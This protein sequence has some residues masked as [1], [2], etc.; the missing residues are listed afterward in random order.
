MNYVLAELLRHMG[1]EGWP[2]LVA[3]RVEQDLTLF[4]LADDG[5]LKVDV[6]PISNLGDLFRESKQI[7]ARG[8]VL[9]LELGEEDHG[10]QLCC[11]VVF[12]T[13]NRDADKNFKELVKA[14]L[15]WLLDDP[16]SVRELQS[17]A[18]CMF[19]MGDLLDP[20]DATVEETLSLVSRRYEE[21][22]G[23]PRMVLGSGTVFADWCRAKN[24][25]TSVKFFKDFE[26]NSAFSITD[27]AKYFMSPTISPDVKVPSLDN[28]HWQFFTNK[29]ALAA[30][31]LCDGVP[32]NVRFL[33]DFGLTYQVHEAMVESALRGDVDLASHF[34]LTTW[35]W[36]KDVNGEV[37]TDL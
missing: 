1:D 32:A 34:R 36:H 37:F 30:E 11:P 28:W 19:A 14:G 4:S 7:K 29:H 23:L 26:D 24:S 13:S 22:G 3:L 25:I 8:G 9:V 27:S 35:E 31:R 15:M 12:S 20:D 10:V 33:R 6:K 21:V 2:P 18:L 16:W 17:A 5:S